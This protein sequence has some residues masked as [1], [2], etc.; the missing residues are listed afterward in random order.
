VLPNV[1]HGYGLVS[2]GSIVAVVIWIVVSW[3][4]RVFVGLF[5]SYARSYGALGAV[6]ML[7][8]WI[9]LSGIAVIIGAEVNAT[10]ARFQR[11]AK[12]GDPVT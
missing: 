3:G 4:F 7:L 6:V 12:E 9:Y 2:L 5:G 8:T 11:E 1:R 10:L